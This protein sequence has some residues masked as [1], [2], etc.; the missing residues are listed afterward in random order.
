MTG[1]YVRIGYN[2]L[3]IDHE[4]MWSTLKCEARH[5]ADNPQAIIAEAR[6]LGSP[7]QCD[8]GCC[9]LDSYADNYSEPFG[10]AGHPVSIHE[11]ADEPWLVQHASTADP[12][13]Y[14][15]RRAFIRLLIEAM[16]RKEIEVSMSVS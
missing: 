12:I 7:E 6:R 3:R 9:D 4:K 5:I 2:P 15:V 10:V 1:Y 16:H 13:K 8:D 14:H 11:D